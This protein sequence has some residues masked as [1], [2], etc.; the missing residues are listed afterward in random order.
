MKEILYYAFLGLLG[1]GFILSMWV[2]FIKVIPPI[3]VIIIDDKPA[4]M[5]RT[6][7]I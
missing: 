4:V 5:L 1:L 6:I 2:I 7:K 3:K